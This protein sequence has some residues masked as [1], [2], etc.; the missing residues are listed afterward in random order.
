MSSLAKTAAAALDA[1]QMTSD[2]AS[3]LTTHLLTRGHEAEVLDFLSARP[4]H[5]VVMAGF[6]LDN[7]LESPLNRGVFYTCRDADGRLEGVAL[8]GHLTML[9][10]RSHAAIKL[11][12]QLAQRCTRA[13]I[14]MGEREKVRKFWAE[15]KASGQPPRLLC[16]ELL[17]EQR[18][19][20]AVREEVRGLR[21]A[22]L[23]DL[24][25]IVPVHAQIASEESGVNP[26]ATD[27]AAFRA[28]CARRIGQGR[29]WVWIK[30]G[31]LIF[32]VDVVS[33]LP[34][35]IYLE[36][37]YIDPQER[38]KGHGLRCLSQVSRHL[39][40]RAE[41]ICLLVNEKNHEAQSLYRRAGF[42]LRSHYDT[43]FLQQASA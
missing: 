36:G 25:L 19:P 33:E 42:H 31:R 17:L 16:Q 22:T 39:L 40:K 9:E 10:V 41:S 7:G 29:V 30:N 1:P 18:W 5:T 32:K 38:G 3:S 8:I 21:L 15:Y 34:Q 23:A 28:R 4:I 37:T 14:I 24:D 2:T 12:A 27:P 35:V 26:L 43:I 6:I 13:N 20:A 11:F